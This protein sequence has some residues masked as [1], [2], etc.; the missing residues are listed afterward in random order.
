MPLSLFLP[1]PH[2]D[3]LEYK[4]LLSK[5]QI[6]KACTNAEVQD[7]I[8]LLTTTVVEVVV[9]VVVALLIVGVVGAVVTSASLEGLLCKR[10][11]SQSQRKLHFLLSLL[12][13]TSFM[14]IRFESLPVKI[15]Y[16]YTGT[17]FLA[18]HTLSLLPTTLSSW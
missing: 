11:A 9:V 16:Q 4:T 13:S 3:S 6:D 12:G 14:L 5:T 7:R 8:S 15:Y 1:S 2:V 18:V 17:R 10:T